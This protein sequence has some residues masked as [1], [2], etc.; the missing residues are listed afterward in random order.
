MTKDEAL[1][2]ALEALTHLQPTALNSFYT[3]GARDKA[4]TAIK[5]ALAAPVQPCYCPNCE[6]MGKEL[7]ALKTQPAPANLWLYWK[8]DD[9]GVVTGPLKT[10]SKDVAY[11][12]DCIDQTHLIVPAEPVQEP[13]IEA[14]HGITKGQP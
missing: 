11:G 9:K 10:D 7:A 14:A 1:K 12:Q 2:L 13:T 8:V 6:A 4:I 3:I 5:Q